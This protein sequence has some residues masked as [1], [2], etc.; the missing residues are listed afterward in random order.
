MLLLQSVSCICF[1]VSSRRDLKLWSCSSTALWPPFQIIAH[2]APNAGKNWLWLEN[3][4]GSPASW[5]VIYFRKCCQA[6]ITVFCSVT[7]W[8]YVGTIIWPLYDPLKDCDVRMWGNKA[9]MIKNRCNKSKSLRPVIAAVFVSLH[10]TKV[11]NRTNDI[12]RNLLLLCERW[13][14]AV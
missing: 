4:M 2:R 7:S 3:K 1:N 6:E 11:F 8:D 5:V 14:D 13:N 9:N 12:L 10:S